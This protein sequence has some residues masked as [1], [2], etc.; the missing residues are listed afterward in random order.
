MHLVALKEPCHSVIR[1]HDT[2]QSE[3]M[4]VALYTYMYSRQVLE[5]YYFDDL[6]RLLY[7]GIDVRADRYLQLCL[8]SPQVTLSHGV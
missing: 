4:F 7:V 5:I 6:Y 2:S 1:S 3:T 8:L